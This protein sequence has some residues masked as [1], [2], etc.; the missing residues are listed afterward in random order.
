MVDGVSLAVG[1]AV[2]IPCGVAVVVALIFWF[3]MQRRLKKEVE[4]DAESMSDDRAI[5]FNNMEALKQ[6]ENSEKEDQ[7]L[8][9]ADVSSYSDNT[10]GV[11]SGPASA[12]TSAGG[13]FNG[14]KKTRGTSVSRSKTKSENKNTYMPAYRKK[15]NSSISSLQQRTR[16][17]DDF[18]GT[19]DSSSTSLD[20]KPNGTQRSEPT[21]LDQ[22]IPVLG[23]PNGTDSGAAAT[24][25]F[26]LS[27]EK[28]ASN[29]NLIKN[30]H[31][32]DFG[33]YPR[34][35]SSANLTSMA[36][37]NVSSTSVRTRSSSA[38]SPKNSTENVFDTPNS[39]VKVMNSLPNHTG[40]P[41][42]N[43]FLKDENSDDNEKPSYYMLKNN[44]DVQNSSEIAEEDQY[45]N[46]FTN[47]SESKREFIN[48]LRP[49]KN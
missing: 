34:R 48:S 18:K 4:E 27:H 14:L 21:V 9:N 32:H 16:H 43:I 20:T 7:A 12:P 23:N 19:T 36:S 40:S 2:G 11:E 3:Y 5:S 41:N 39:N 17:H 44:Y 15:L 29:D 10:Q 46:D 47:Y 25:E 6:V 37:G 30:L 31:N 8:Q 49:R 13:V 35:R 22:M 26:S 33:S 1:C 38:H 42:G 28:T 45:E 24:S